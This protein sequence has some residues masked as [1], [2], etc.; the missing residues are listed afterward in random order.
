MGTGK[1][2]DSS[3]D[4]AVQ[5]IYYLEGIEQL[6]AISEPIRY[7]MYCRMDEPKTGAQLARDLGISRARAHYHLNILKEAGLVVFCG[8]GS[9]HGITEKYYRMIALNLDF[10]NL[11]PKSNRRVVPD[12]ITLRSFQAASRFIATMLD[13]SRERISQL[14]V[15][16]RV[17]LGYHYTLE[18]RLTPDQFQEIKDGL[19]ALKDR[20]VEMN[21][22]N[23]AQGQ[24]E[25]VVDC[26]V[27]LF[28]TPLSK[29]AAEAVATDD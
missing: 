18:S 10:S 24:H 2:N 27:T 14:K 9:S 20:I 19:V 12:Q 21:R 7:R 11:I 28:L 8:K 15:H 5:D 13:I 26:G 23:L 6:E 16:N 4:C 25:L 3:E 17:G 22:E 29:Q 1:T